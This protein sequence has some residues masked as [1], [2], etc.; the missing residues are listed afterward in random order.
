[1]SRG[2][3]ARSVALVGLLS[4]LAAC[5]VP[6]DSGPRDIPAKE[7]PFGLLTTTTATRASIAGVKRTV[8]FIK[9]NRLAPVERDVS[10]P[11]A[12]PQVLAVIAAGPSAPEAQRGLRTA[13]TTKVAS[14]R[15]SGGLATVTLSGSFVNSPIREQILALSQIVYTATA[16][17]GIGGVEI[18][19]GG[20]LAEVPTAQGS[21]KRGALTRADYAAIATR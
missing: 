21:L 3:V 15:S 16:V 20:G 19:L 12:L 18:W 9:D 5:G 1:V 6:T 7:I 14:V 2:R 17:D 10:P 8:F 11:A 4:T 13:L